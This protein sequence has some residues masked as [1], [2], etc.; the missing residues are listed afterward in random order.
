MFLDEDADEIVDALMQII[1][2]ITIH[3]NKKPKISCMLIES[4]S[5]NNSELYQ[6]F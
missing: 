4:I 6:I 5:E 3:W 1:I 2:L